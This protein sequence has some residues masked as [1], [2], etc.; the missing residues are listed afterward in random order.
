MQMLAVLALG[1]CNCPTECIMTMRFQVN[2]TQ[3]YWIAEM[4]DPALWAAID[5]LRKYE[6]VPIGFICNANH[7][8]L[9]TSSR[10]T[11]ASLWVDSENTV[12]VSVHRYL[13]TRLKVQSTNFR[14]FGSDVLRAAYT[15]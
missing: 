6:C 8:E 5:M 10:A 7:S 14:I 3:L 1:T 12:W 13:G 4:T 2:G 9:R 15:A 11:R